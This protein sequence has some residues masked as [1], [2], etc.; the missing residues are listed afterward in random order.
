MLIIRF[1]HTA[2]IKS[3]FFSI[4]NISKW[5][6]TDIIFTIA[7][8][9]YCATIWVAR[10][11]E[12]WGKIAF[13]VWVNHHDVVS[14]WVV[15]VVLQVDIVEFGNEVFE[16]SFLQYLLNEIL[17]LI[18]SPRL[19]QL[20]IILNNKLPMFNPLFFNTTRTLTFCMDAVGLLEWVVGGCRDGRVSLAEGVVLEQD[21]WV[22]F[23]KGWK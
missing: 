7:Y 6:H 15:F 20:S 1:R 8:C 16:F 5:V 11:G 13:F 18:P 23:V 9:C 2:I 12:S 14:L 10:M 19:I 3:Q 21:F 4:F 17:S 22:Q